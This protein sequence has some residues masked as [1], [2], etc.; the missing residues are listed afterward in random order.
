MKL[1]RNNLRRIILEEMQRMND[2]FY[3][4]K[5]S[6][7]QSLE[8]DDPDHPFDF[9][10]R[11][12]VGGEEIFEDDKTELDERHDQWAR[13]DYGHVG[14]LKR[15]RDYDKGIGDLVGAYEDEKHIDALKGDAH[16]DKEDELDWLRHHRE[17]H[18]IDEDDGTTITDPEQIQWQSSL[19][20]DSDIVGADT[21]DVDTQVRA[22][23][24][25]SSLN[26]GESTQGLSRGSLYRKRYYGRY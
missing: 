14:A 21:T 17:G 20:E 6:P 12:K 26:I 22:K 7:S 23:E 2:A 25:D 24:N 3:Y 1:N 15:D 5:D 16:Y 13:G 8:A 11:D 19:E 10:K 4:G 9:S 18:S